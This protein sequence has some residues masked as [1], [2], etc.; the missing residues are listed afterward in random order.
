MIRWRLDTRAGLRWGMAFLAIGV[1]AA[2]GY[3]T[4]RTD[5]EPHVGV[6]TTADSSG[7]L[8]VTWVQPAGLAWDAGVRPG[9]VI[10]TMTE[11][12]PPGVPL[13]T[14]ARGTQV[15]MPSPSGSQHREWSFPLLAA[16]YVICGALVFV[17]ARQVR[18]AACVLIAVTAFAVMLMAGTVTQYGHAWALAAVYASLVLG[19]ASVLILALVFPRNR[20][21]SRF[22]TAGAG[23]SIAASMALIGLYIWTLDA[24]SAAYE[25]VQRA[26]LSVVTLELLGAG[27]LAWQVAF[28]RGASEERSRRSLRIV[29]VGTAASFAPFCL[30]TLAPYTLGLN[31]LPADVT[32]LGFV[33][34]PASLGATVVRGELM[35]VDR[36]VRR[37]AVAVVVWTALA[38][39]AMVCVELGLRIAKGAIGPVE[40][41]WALLVL[42]LAG[43]AVFLSLQSFLR[44]KIE[45][46]LLPD[47]YNYRRT[48]DQ[49]S[50]EIV[51]LTEA[52]AIA[53]HT[54]IRLNQT[55]RIDGSAIVLGDANNRS[56]VYRVGTLPTSI[57]DETLPSD[58]GARVPLVVQGQEIGIL[59]VGRKRPDVDLTADDNLL[60]RTAAA[61]VSTALRNA[62]LLGNLR[63]QVAKLAEREHQLLA[64]SSRL[65]AVQEEERRAIALDVHDDALQRAILLARDIAEAADDP[66]TRRLRAAADDVIAALRAVCMGLRPPLLDELGL[67]AGL[68]RLLS[69]FSARTDLTARLLVDFD[70]SR[71]TV[72]VHKDLELALYR[73]TQEALN[74]CAK[75]SR[76]TDVCVLLRYDTTRLFLE[77]SDNGTA[78]RRS[79][80][81]ASQLGLLGMRERLRPW[82]GTVSVETHPTSGTTVTA[83]VPLVH[84]ADRSPDGRLLE[85]VRHT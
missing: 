17:T 12:S 10:L 61:L 31:Y 16:L 30:L 48:I 40:S 84:A 22:K 46:L 54:L 25:I 15:F 79:D 65:M 78:I 4:A 34:L 20:L 44:A 26:V 59:F 19:A 58:W 3:A 47:V 51:C 24:D 85:V 7:Q 11:T 13:L 72:R 38:S 5:R 62:L 71:G 52:R 42:L 67:E 76:A 69:E 43:A 35:A 80:G 81:D 63:E 77:I 21:P 60:V 53:E 68:R 18:P 36:A 29:A 32:I 74:N 8:K 23:A 83:E 28:G 55:L 2:V 45:R 14:T 57:D 50:T 39:A 73:V 49:L 33:F 75:H 82:S 64:L 6:A 37:A 1:V 66:R 27:A 56:Q 9:D 41:A 70:D